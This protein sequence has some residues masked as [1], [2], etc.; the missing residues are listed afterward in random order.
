MLLLRVS[1]RLAFASGADLSIEAYRR[2]LYQP[3]SVHVARNS[4]EIISG[5]TNKVNGVVFEVLLPLLTLVSS[6]VL[7]V[8][9]VF[10]LIAI[11]SEVALGVALCFGVSYGL[12]TLMSHRRLKRNSKRIALEQTQAAI[13][14]GAGVSPFSSASSS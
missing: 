10:A 14:T 2:T 12:I 1:T 7:Q 9:I 8:V 3:Y 6:T 13:E 4:S 11:N 5:I